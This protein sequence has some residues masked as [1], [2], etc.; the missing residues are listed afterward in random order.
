MKRILG[1]ASVTIAVIA[2][3]TRNLVFGYMVIRSL[4][5]LRIEN[6]IADQARNDR[7]GGLLLR[8]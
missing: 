5:K 1:E 7:L 4:D 2:G 8:H 6:Q 3:L